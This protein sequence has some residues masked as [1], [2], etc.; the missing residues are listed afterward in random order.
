MREFRVLLLAVVVS[1]FVLGYY[2][3]TLTYPLIREA[4]KEEVY[5]ELPRL[6][7]F[8]LIVAE[9][10][11]VRYLS[12]VSIGAV[13]RQRAE[14]RKEEAKPPS[15]RLS[16]TFLGKKKYAIINGRLFREGERVSPHE[17]IVRIL[18][19]KVLLSG[20][21]GRRWLMLGE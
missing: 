20:R 3:H 8:Q 19:G 21:W 1:A 9:E 6:P 12:E 14:L 2:I 4:V 7:D 18:E 13:R 16:F 15:Y 10:V 11:P 17:R 5:K